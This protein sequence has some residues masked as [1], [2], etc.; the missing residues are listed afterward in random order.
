MALPVNC[1]TI[2]TQLLHFLGAQKYGGEESWATIKAHSY[3]KV[4][5][6]LGARKAKKSEL[7]EEPEA[8]RSG[9][10]EEQLAEAEV[11][12]D[13]MAVPP[14]YLRGVL[15]EIYQVST[16]CTAT[17]RLTSQTKP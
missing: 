4:K 7:V 16:E 1:L 8:K 12:C 11:L 3:K 2:T 17:Q 13:L 14:E 10:S 15:S 6:L 5:E 9:P